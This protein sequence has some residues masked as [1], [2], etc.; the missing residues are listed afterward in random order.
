MIIRGDYSCLGH[1]HIQI[2]LKKDRIDMWRERERE[3]EREKLKKEL[4]EIFDWNF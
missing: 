4:T 1:N 2:V 3:R